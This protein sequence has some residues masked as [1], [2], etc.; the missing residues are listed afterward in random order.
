MDIKNEKIEGNGIIPDIEV[1]S[2][3]TDESDMQL[4]RAIEVMEEL[5]ASDSEQRGI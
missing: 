2:E 5:L 3:G 1:A 4:Q